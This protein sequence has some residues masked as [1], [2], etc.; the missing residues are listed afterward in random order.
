[1]VDLIPLNDVLRQQLDAR[2]RRLD[3]A[4]QLTFTCDVGTPPFVVRAQPL[5]LRQVFTML[6]ENAVRAMRSSPTKRLSVRSLREVDRVSV[7]ISDTGPGFPPEI[8][9]DVFVRQIS[10]RSGGL[11]IGLLLARSILNQCGGD[12]RLVDTNAAG[13]TIEVWLPV[14]PTDD[15]GVF[16]PY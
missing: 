1:V 13:S 11:G 7:T 15:T 8:V 12:V 6:I 10:S 2:R 9:E 5:L 14:H 16:G 4:Y 3:R